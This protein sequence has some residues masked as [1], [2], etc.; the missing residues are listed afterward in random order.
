MKKFLSI[1][2]KPVIA[3]LFGFVS[4]GLLVSLVHIVQGSAFSIS[5]ANHFIAVVSSGLGGVVIMFSIRKLQETTQ[6]LHENRNL[7]SN[8]INTVPQ[9]IWSAQLEKG[10]EIRLFTSKGV[11]T[12]TGYPREKM[13]DVESWLAIVHPDDLPKVAAEVPRHHQGI[14][15]DSEYRIIHADGSIRWV[16]GTITPTI[17]ASGTVVRLEGT[18]EDITER[19]KTEEALRESEAR[20]RTLFDDSPIAIWEE[21]FSAIKKRID[22]LRAEGITDFE[23]Y[24]ETHPDEVAALAAQIKVIDV[25]QAAVRQHEAES[26]SALRAGLGKTFGKESLK[27]FR[28][29][30]L[31]LIRGETTFSSDSTVYTQTGNP[32]YVTVDVTV[33]PGAEKTWHRMIVSTIN[34]TERH[35][36]ETALKES[37][38][39]YRDLVEAIPSGIAISTG[40][41]IKFANNALAKIVRVDSTDV[42]L[43]DPTP[44]TRLFPEDQQVAKK[45]IAT[46]MEHPNA[47]M[48]PIEL[49][50]IGPQN[51]VIY[52]ESTART[53]N[54]RG[55]KAILSI[56]NDIS[57]R[58]LL[59]NQLHQS[60]KMEAVGRLAGGIAHDF[61][62]LLTA[63]MGYTS[64]IGMQIPKDNNVHQDL[65][66]IKKAADRAAAL[67]RQLLAFSRQQTTQ[68][69]LW[70]INQ[71]VTDIKKMLRRLI[72]ENIDL[73]TFLAPHL[74]PIKIDPGHLEQIIMNIAIN[75][76]DAMP[77]G[78]KL[79]IETAPVLLDENYTHQHPEV[80]PGQYVLLAISDTGHGISA[81]VREHI[82]EPFFTTKEV[83]KGTGLGLATVYGIVKQNNGHI[84]LYSEIER[85]TTFKIYF[86]AEETPETPVTPISSHIIPPPEHLTGT[87]TILLVEDEQLV[88]ELTR[89]FLLS[90]GYT[91]LEATNSA[92]ALAMA[93]KARIP[94]DLLLTDVV[95]PGEMNGR[96]LSQTIQQDSPGTSVIFMSGYTDSVIVHHQILEPGLNFIQKPFSPMEL[97]HFVRTVLDA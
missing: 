4:T 28:Q 54:Y 7:L 14:S 11:E 81:D 39:R 73:Q 55:E 77:D 76:R 60:Q 36:M 56:V 43:T 96:E 45:H 21:D 34:I 82:F 3:E 79:T 25:N 80:S 53:I 9:Y 85:G 2:L 49:H 67:I 31:A 52:L 47:V 6:A 84:W 62:N 24:F 35:N 91:V 37:E 74:M 30:L 57:A 89:K 70:D 5:S 1:L 94:I 92:E 32:L 88:R 17:D 38:L 86:P 64:L 71:T 18:I 20:Y 59:E 10:Q 19:K 12:I 58:K 40:T 44:L 22:A 13:M 63:I 78:G 61:N 48:P 69:R 41:K 42:L 83:G 93:K 51:E 75:A 68:P 15:A 72:G 50:L 65:A 29:E 26:K 46:L 8:I 33:T 95:M 16:H 66:E 87:E 90:L 97:A 27:T 23:A